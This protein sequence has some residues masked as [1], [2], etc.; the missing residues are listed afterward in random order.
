ME[1]VSENKQ[2][3]FKGA[4]RYCGGDVTAWCE[5]WEQDDAGNWKADTVATQCSTEP[6]ID[7][8]EWEDW[9][10][11]HSDLPYVYILPMHQQI[12][13]HIN[14]RYKFDLS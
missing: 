8:E 2:F 3:E 4:C 9:F 6:D 11:S 14:E 10:A 12:I 7:S 13:K 5:G 1:L